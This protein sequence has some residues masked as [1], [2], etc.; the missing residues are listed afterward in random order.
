MR[1]RHEKILLS[2]DDIGRILL[3][4]EVTIDALRTHGSDEVV[5]ILSLKN[6]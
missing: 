4:Q 1:Y 5:P 3:G 6:K 2:I